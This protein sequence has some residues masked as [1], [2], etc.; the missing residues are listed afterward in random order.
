[1]VYIFT[2]RDERSDPL[3]KLSRSAKLRICA[4]VLNSS[5]FE[6]LV[7]YVPDYEQFQGFCHEKKVS[8]ELEGSPLMEWMLPCTAELIPLD[9]DYSGRSVQMTTYRV[10]RAYNSNM[11]FIW[12][13]SA[14]TCTLFGL[15]KNVSVIVDRCKY[16]N[17]IEF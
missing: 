1:M 11:V 8:M 15:S 14:L 2:A 12:D 16:P 4:S 3:C 17:C 10:S 7:R 9:N 13:C 6:L 5:L